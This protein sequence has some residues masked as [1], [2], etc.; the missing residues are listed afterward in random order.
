MAS[1]YEHMMLFMRHIGFQQF[2]LQTT[3]IEAL[4]RQDLLFAH[5]KASHLSRRFYEITGVEP[6]DY[7]ELAFALTGVTR[8]EPSPLWIGRATFRPIQRGL[9]E[10]ALEG[11]LAHLSKSIPEMNAWLGCQGF[12]NVSVAD[13][14]ILPTPFLQAPLLRTN[15]DQY[16]VIF[17]TLLLQ[18]LESVIYRTLRS[19]AP[20]EFGGR[21]GPLFEDYARRCLVDSGLLHLNESQLKERLPF[22]SKCVDFL[23]SHEECDVLI[24]A[25]GVEMSRLGR[26]S[27]RADLVLQAVKASAVKAIEQANATVLNLTVSSPSTC[28][29]S[30]GRES[31]LVVVTFDDLYLGGNSM[32][33]EVFGTHLIS[34]LERDFGTPLP[35]PFENM[36]FIS[37][38]E[39][40]RLLGYARE[41]VEKLVE[42]LRYARV[43][44]EEPRTRKFKFQQHLDSFPVLGEALPM[45]QAGLDDLKARCLH[46]AKLGDVE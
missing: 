42:L 25:K 28:I 34:R 17:P 33:G 11:F 21:F 39:F 45:L 14:R 31:F 35:I 3:S 44:E 46:R 24:D 29:P 10:G 6:R 8:K 22:G 32:F 41:S 40:E 5:P 4:V 15:E 7:M 37:I 26:L 9:S 16:F 2:S 19:D 30:A 1:S 12:K 18:S 36:F 20:I 27:Q 43:Q 38:D 13:Q 23:I